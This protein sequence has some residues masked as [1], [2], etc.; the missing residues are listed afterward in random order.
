MIAYNT[1]IVLL[2]VALLGTGAGL[3]GSFAVLRRRALLG[4]ALAHAALPG[5]CLGFLAL[6]ERNLAAMLAGALLSGLLGIAVVG[7]LTHFTRVRQDAAIGIVLSVFFGAGIVL[8]RLIQNMTTAIGSKAGLDSYILGK[9]AGIIAAD[10][11]LIAGA[12]VAGIA[13]V[14]LL[15]KEFLLISFDGEF[16]RVQG[17]PARRI[18]LLLTGLLALV[19]VIG[20]PAVG[21]VMMAALLIL[22][23]VT[24]RFWTDRLAPLLLLAAGIGAGVGLVGTALSASYDRLP[25][26]PIITLVGTACFLISA[27]AAPRRGLIA[28]VLARRRDRW[29][30]DYAELLRLLFE[31][32]ERGAATTL[33]AIHQAKSWSRL[34]VQRL[35][36]AAVRLGDVDPGRHALTSP[37][38]DRAIDIVR[39]RRLWQLLMTEYPDLIALANPLQHEPVET[40][41]PEAVVADLTDKLR[42]ARRWPES[43]RDVV[44]VSGGVS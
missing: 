2:G 34:R 39:R 30:A 1:F 27:L 17:W 22:P 19:V 12:A 35:L 8:S 33:E 41:L 26:G 21:V 11:A 42:Q 9:T 20:L 24:A 32:A 6:G 23:G 4:D 37:G 7:L 5:L 3:V 15:F 25:A 16:A 10:V 40:R 29:Q 43:P 28:A 38:R 36:A 18:D 44:G 14:A 13:L 31:D